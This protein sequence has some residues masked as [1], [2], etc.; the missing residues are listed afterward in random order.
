MSGL[1]TPLG[2]PIASITVVNMFKCEACVVLVCSGEPFITGRWLEL[3]LQRQSES[4]AARVALDR[5]RMEAAGRDQTAQRVGECSTGVRRWL[6]CGWHSAGH[7]RWLLFS[8]LSIG[9]RGS[10]RNDRKTDINT[11]GYT[12][13]CF[14]CSILQAWRIWVQFL[15]KIEIMMINQVNLIWIMAQTN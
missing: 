2:R 12:I 9:A 6:F 13:G 15:R 10:P 1:A 7:P 8:E 3:V 14:C 5:D 11:A 4:A